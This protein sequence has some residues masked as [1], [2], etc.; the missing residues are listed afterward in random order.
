[1]STHKRSE[2][3][4]RVAQEIK[5]HQDIVYHLG[6][7]LQVLENKLVALSS[8]NEKLKNEL[9]IVRLNAAEEL[10]DFK[11]WMLDSHG[12]VVARLG[13]VKTILDKLQ[14]KILQFDKAIKNDL[15][16]KQEVSKSSDFI[17]EKITYLHSVVSTNYRMALREVRVHYDQLVAQI[18]E[19]KEELKPKPPLGD[20]IQD[21]IEDNLKT[22]RVDFEG[23]KQE[24]ALLKQAMAYDQKKFEYILTRIE[25]LKEGKL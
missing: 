11:G 13:D 1:M 4:I 3:D 12:L 20:P 10:E 25:R 23:L 9:E 2:V 24:I 19:A 16:S 8:Q 17:D 5:N 18:N 15:A 6:Q 22:V 14:N 7:R 21:K